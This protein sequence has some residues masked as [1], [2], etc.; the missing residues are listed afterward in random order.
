[1]EVVTEIIIIIALT[2][3]ETCKA[4]SMEKEETLTWKGNL[5]KTHE[6]IS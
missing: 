6:N 3:V 5:V 2:K 4:S 1:M